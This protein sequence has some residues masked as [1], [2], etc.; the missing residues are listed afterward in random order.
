MRETQKEYSTPI[1][2]FFVC[3]YV[4]VFV[5]LYVCVFC[6]FICVCFCTQVEEQLVD[7][8][9][10]KMILDPTYYDVVVAP[11]LYGTYFVWCVLSVL[12]TVM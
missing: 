1:K 8:M 12:V 9:V 7:S 3:L 2:W 4:C 5:C 10:Y 6:L 11:N